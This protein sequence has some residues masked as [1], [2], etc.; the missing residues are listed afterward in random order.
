MHNLNKETEKFDAVI[1]GSGQ[2]GNPLAKDLALEG[3]KVAVIEKKFV[4]GSCINYGCTPSKTMYASAKTANFV[5]RS[6]EYGIHT[7]S[8]KVN[9]KEVYKRKK[10]IVESFRRGTLKRL[11]SSENINLIKGKA[12]FIDSNT[13][14]IG[15]KNGTKI[16]N[17]DKI[18]INTGG[19]AVIPAINGLN[20]IPYLDSTSIMELKELP[21]HLLIIGG[22]YIGV[23]FGQMF[24]RF[25]S[26]VTIIQRS[27]QLLNREDPDIA[28]EV[29]KILEEDGIKV[30]LNSDVI[31]LEK[32]KSNISI[33]ISNGKKGTIVS[34]SHVL[35]AAGHKPNTE[36]LNL[37]AAGIKT[38]EKGYIKVNDKLETNIEGIYALGDVKGG[39]AFTHISYDDYRII[40]DNI[41]LK[42][43]KT[44][45]G[46]IVPYVVFIDPQ[47][48]R[49]GLNEIEA[50]KKRIDYSV[51]KMPMNYIARTIEAGETRGLMKII[52]N[53][54]TD[55]ILGCTILGTEGGELMSMIQIAMI[56][57]LKYTILQE[58][59]FTHPTLA[60]SINNVF[61]H[62]EK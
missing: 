47:L 31:K 3:W 35:I 20:K 52:I 26:E 29:K 16:I 53:K 58:A 46:R 60:E 25:G 57:N 8:V 24:K 43:N 34:G 45:K 2:A 7:S 42:K 17:S 39:P 62:I 13:I 27:G 48:G 54:K 30:Y 1:I 22:G 23:E 18:F 59:V 37:P 10:E 28:N 51:A 11:D 33:Y 6:S 19:G 12:S 5:K 49:V 50:K 55:K 40:R 56:G 44:I 4:G 15:L 36:E 21:K 38:D 32:L 9:M 14:K 41:L 61:S